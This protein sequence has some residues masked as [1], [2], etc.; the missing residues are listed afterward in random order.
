MLFKYKTGEHLILSQVYY[1]P[2]FKSNIISYGQLDE[3]GNKIVKEDNVMKIYDKAKSLIIMVIEN[4][5]IV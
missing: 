5:Q 2:V 4:P 3:S 1:I